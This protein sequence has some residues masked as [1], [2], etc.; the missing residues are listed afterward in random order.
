MHHSLRILGLGAALA[1]GGLAL[2][3]V[4]LRKPSVPADAKGGVVK[5]SELREREALQA[6]QANESKKMRM[7][8]ALCVLA[9][10]ALM[11]LS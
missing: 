10:A 9:G 6:A 7:V 4:T 2:F 11:I 5:K 1:L 8:G 3:A